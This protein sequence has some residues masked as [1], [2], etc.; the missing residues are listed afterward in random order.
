MPTNNDEPIPAAYWY[1]V[2]GTG[3]PPTR[4]NLLRMASERRAVHCAG[5]AAEEARRETAAKAKESR[6]EAIAKAKADH[7][8]P[9]FMS[10]IKG[11]LGLG[12]KRNEKDSLAEHDGEESLTRRRSSAEE[13]NSRVTSGE[14]NDAG[15]AAATPEAYPASGSPHDGEDQQLGDDNTTGTAEGS[16]NANEQTDGGGG[17]GD[18]TDAD[19]ETPAAPQTFKNSHHGEA[20]GSTSSKQKAKDG[21]SSPVEAISGDEPDVGDQIQDSSKTVTSS[22]GISPS[23]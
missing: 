10:T 15:A 7:P 12:K 6:K 22:N 1:L 3:P 9:D 16:D 4:S 5:I 14:D 20:V 13:N 19:K 8:L 17:G 18:G 21:A 2:L 11:K 23:L